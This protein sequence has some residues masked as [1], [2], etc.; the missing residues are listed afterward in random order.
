MC[1]LIAHTPF[2][3]ASEHNFALARKALQAVCFKYDDACLMAVWQGECWQL[4]LHTARYRKLLQCY[5]N[6]DAMLK[7]SASDCA[8]ENSQL[9]TQQHD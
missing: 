3:T 7:A 8:I 2:A 5:C 6:A 9:A 4:S 1:F